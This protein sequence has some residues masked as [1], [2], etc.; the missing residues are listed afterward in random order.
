M[1]SSTAAAAGAEKSAPA[2]ACINCGAGLDKITI[3][4]QIIVTFRLNDE[5]QVYM[6]RGDVTDQDFV[7]KAAEAGHDYKNGFCEV[8][9]T[10]MGMEY[11]QD[12]NVIAFNDKP[13]EWR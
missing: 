11:D 4:A 8:C 12:G 5:G 2:L 7:I 6:L 3:D 13:A 1:V 10:Y 9:G